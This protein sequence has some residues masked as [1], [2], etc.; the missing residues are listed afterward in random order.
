MRTAVRIAAA[1]SLAVIVGLAVEVIREERRYRA[2]WRQRG[3]WGL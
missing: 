3:P 1:F 2:H